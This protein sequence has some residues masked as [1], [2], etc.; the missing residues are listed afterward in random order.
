MTFPATNSKYKI[1]NTTTDTQINAGA[2][3]VTLQDIN[4]LDFKYL[5]VQ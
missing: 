4:G 5:E 1:V 2:Y 3:T